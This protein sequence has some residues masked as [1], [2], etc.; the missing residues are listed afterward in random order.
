M[1]SRKHIY[2]LLAQIPFGDLFGSTGPEIGDEEFLKW[3]Q[4]A[5]KLIEK[6]ESKLGVGWAVKILNVYLKTAAYVG[7][8][9]RPGLRELLHPPIDAGL[10]DGMKNW[11][12]KSDLSKAERKELKKNTH[13]V[14]KIKDITDYETYE[15]IISGCRVIAKRIDCKLVEVD[16]LWEG[17]SAP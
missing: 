1:K 6:A 5:E 14:Q 11:I 12:G 10:W 4:D 17:A 15:A 16:H 13:R 3:H 2:P 7:D 8:L 9:G